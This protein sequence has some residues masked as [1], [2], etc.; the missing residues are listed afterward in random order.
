[1]IPPMLFI[2]GFDK[3]RYVE[4]IKAKE[5]KLKRKRGKTV[6]LDGDPVKMGR[7]MEMKIIPLSL[8]VIVP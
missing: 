5:V 2:P 3:S 1:M 7:E 8:N 4:V 6:H